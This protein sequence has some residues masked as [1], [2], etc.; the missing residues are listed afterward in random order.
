MVSKPTGL[1]F[2]PGAR[3]IDLISEMQP[4]DMGETVG[5]VVA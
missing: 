1:L 2:S 5:A 3:M 4:L